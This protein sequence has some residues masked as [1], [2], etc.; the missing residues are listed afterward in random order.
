MGGGQSRT[1]CNLSIQASSTPERTKANRIA[2]CHRTSVLSAWSM[3]TKLSRSSIA[4]IALIDATTLSLTT[5]K[6]TIPSS[7][8]LC[9]KSG[10]H[11]TNRSK[12]ALLII[13]TRFATKTRSTSLRTARTTC[14]LWE[15]GDEV[16]QFSE[17]LHKNDQQPRQQTQA[18]WRNCPA[19]EPHPNP[20]DFVQAL[21]GH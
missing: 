20:R 9:S 10:A 21:F 15:L 5:A 19:R 2:S 1:G 12:P 7:G 17:K 18:K 8:E 16:R 14:R 13:R 4:A 11:C 3:L 6:S